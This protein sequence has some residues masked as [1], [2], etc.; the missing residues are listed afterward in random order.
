[1]LKDCLL[2]YYRARCDILEDAFF[3]SA[4]Y[5]DPDS[6]HDLRVEIKQLRAFF[7]LLEFIAPK[8]KAKK[9][10]QRFRALFKAAGD[11]RDVHVQQEL[12]RKWSQ[13]LGEF[14]SEYYNSLKQ[15]EFPAREI[16]S[17]FAHEF[18]L[19]KE[20]AINR[21][22]ISHALKGL[23][24]KEL[25]ERLQQRINAQLQKVLELGTQASDDESRLH[26]LRIHS[27]ETRYTLDIA[28]RCLP[29][30]EY[31]NALNDRLRALHH[32]L[33]KWHDGDVARDHILEFQQEARV[34]EGNNPQRHSEI[35]QQLLQQMQAEKA[36]HLESFHIAWGEFLALLGQEEPER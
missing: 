24:Q 36:T 12:T 20:I 10:I 15:K 17:Q 35:Y 22:R 29:E 7:R 11:L 26:K 30:S 23:L 16:F 13:E 8:F 14:M 18:E 25:S 19:E 3:K 4:T 5:F 1:M 32:T 34:A 33:G 2:A 28:K 9:H 6:I 31:W 27:K 21:K